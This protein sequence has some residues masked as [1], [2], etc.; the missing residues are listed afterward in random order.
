MKIALVQSPYKDAVYET[1]SMPLGL[2]WIS[3][4]IKSKIDNINITGYDML[5]KPELE[6]TLYDE[7]RLNKFNVVGIQAHSNMTIDDTIRII[8]T[9]KKIDKNIIIVA[10]GNA[11]TYMSNYL[12]QKSEIDIIIKGEGE[13]TFYE[14]ICALINKTEF[15]DIKGLIYRSHSDVVETQDRQLIEDLDIL[16]FPDRSIFDKY[17][18]PQYGVMLSRGCPYNCTFCSTSL[19]WKYKVRLRSPKYVIQEINYL[20]ERYNLKKLFVLDDTFGINNNKVKEFLYD[21]K[22]ANV[23]IEWACVTRADVVN[24]EILDLCKDAGCV[25]IHFGLDTANKNTQILINK[26]LNIETLIKMC[27]YSKHIGIRTKL[28]IILG[29]P[30]E[31]MQ[32]IQ[33]TIE[34]LKKIMPNEIQIYPLMPY[35]GTKIIED[36][37]SKI[38]IIEKEYSK[39]KQDALNPVIESD[40]LTYQELIYIAQK[41]V[42]EFRQLGY[43]CIPFD[44]EPIKKNEQYIVKTVF[45]PLQAL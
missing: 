35:V 37:D 34:I 9:I 15:K 27:N 2:C 11:A 45:A 30:N 40:K 14:L 8:N 28:S 16:P 21:L 26:N 17:N 18:Y 38:H 32:D 20:K 36:K 7:V 1:I 25:E 33:Y 29:L 24:E 44:M 41:S 4:Y 22:K 42:E 3:S 19:F 13:L 12:L 31:S 39:W 23:N 5:L 10:G 6:K 43:K